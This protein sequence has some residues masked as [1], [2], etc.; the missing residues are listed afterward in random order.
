[1]RCT[2]GH[3]SN[4]GFCTEDCRI[5]IALATIFTD[6]ISI[7]G[8]VNKSGAFEESKR[9]NVIGIGT[10]YVVIAWLVAH[11]GT[12]FSEASQLRTAILMPGNGKAATSRTC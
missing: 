11:Q 1:M 8:L 6:D 12:C 2:M 7:Q 5:R 4:P 9:R 10:G 3:V